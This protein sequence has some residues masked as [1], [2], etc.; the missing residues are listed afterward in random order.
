MLVVMVSVV[1]VT[2][3]IAAAIVRIITVDVREA[4]VIVVVK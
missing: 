1:I 3:V 4:V 2:A